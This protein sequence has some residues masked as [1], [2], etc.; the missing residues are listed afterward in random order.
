MKLGRFDEAIADYDS[1][2]KLAP[3]LA[4]SLYGRGAAK[5]KKGDTDGGNA[6]IAAAKAIQA[7]VADD[8]AGYG[9][10]LGG[11]PTPGAPEAPLPATSPP[12]TPPPPVS[13]VT[14]G[15]P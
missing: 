14:S 8:F 3:Q 2:L 5:L 10:A 1:A 12:A 9:V 6:D 4:S 13:G 7:D 11:G 15:K